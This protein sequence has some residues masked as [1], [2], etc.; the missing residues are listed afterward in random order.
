MN[1]VFM[2]A[3]TVVGVASIL[4]AFG[5][6]STSPSGDIG[7][8]K[9]RHESSIMGVPGVVGVGIGECEGEPC[10]RVFVEDR[11]PE[12][13]RRIPER[14]EGFKVD[15]EATGPIQALIETPPEER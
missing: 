11:T 13:E 14:L 5:G 9:E 12:L 7:A 3:S 10:I 6:G 1:I 15:I 8:A 2:L 4:A